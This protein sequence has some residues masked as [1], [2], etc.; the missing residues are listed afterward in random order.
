MKNLLKITA[1]L[2]IV[3]GA[4]ACSKK[5]DIDMSQIDF[6]NIENLYAQPLPVI[7][8]AVQ[9]EWKWMTY[10]SGI[11]G[12]IPVN[13]GAVEISKDEFRS[14]KGVQRIA[15]Q[16][17]EV[18]SYM[19]NIK[20]CVMCESPDNVPICFFEHIINDTMRVS[21][22]QFRFDSHEFIRIKNN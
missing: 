17:R 18:E 1:V 10:I 13:N 14:Y 16:E 3:A 21:G 11:N 8:K 4:F 7:Q 9:G 12:W 2:L 20:T 15:W 22:F 6:S 5:E 19:G